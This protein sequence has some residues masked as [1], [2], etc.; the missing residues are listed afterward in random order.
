M[1]PV[2]LLI[3]CVVIGSQALLR[4]QSDVTGTLQL[5]IS[6]ATTTFRQGEAVEV[7]LVVTNAA[8]GEV[9]VTTRPRIANVPFAFRVWNSD[10]HLLN[11]DRISGDIHTLTSSQLPLE[12]LIFK[13]HETTF[14]IDLRDYLARTGASTLPA[15]KLRVDALLTVLG[16]KTALD[17]KSNLVSRATAKVLASNPIEFTVEK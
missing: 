16:S 3:L 14:K 4:S 7:T 17:R 13:P 8:K 11:A 15:G 9:N 6:L 12:S 1:R 5:S 10:G 2:F